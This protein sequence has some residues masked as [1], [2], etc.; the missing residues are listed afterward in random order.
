VDWRCIVDPPR[1]GAANMAL[2][3]ALFEGVQAGGRPVLRLYRWEPACLSFGRNQ[4]AR[5]VYDRARAAS[6][7]VDI[8]RRPT[9]GLAVYHHHELTYAVIAGTA[10]I[11]RPRAAYTAI[12]RALADGLSR[13][14]VPGT[15]AMGP[16]V[17]IPVASA[18]HPCFGEAAA[19]EVVVEGRKIVGS[20]SRIEKHTILQHGSILIDGDQSE[21]VALQTSVDGWAPPA[22]AALRGVL[23]RVPDW[24]ELC[25]AIIA[26]FTATLGLRLAPVRP[27]PA[28]CERARRLED[29]F[30]SDTWTWRR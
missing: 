16:A 14:G 6:R 9:G 13:L 4:T 21:V 19:G 25:A 26:G 15:I 20:A 3:R 8:V 1:T 22:A 10:H 5:G 11:G 30:R 12:N 27:D 28:D 29:R 24:S 23:G 2:D 18:R 7:G 17:P